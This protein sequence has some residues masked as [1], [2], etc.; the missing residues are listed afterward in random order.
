MKIIDLHNDFLT[1][2]N[3]M[4]I[5]NFLIKSKFSEVDK[6][7]SSIYTT[8]M[9]NKVFEK[10]T[11]YKKLLNQSKIKPKTFLHI[12]DCGF[13][14]NVEDVEKL[15]RIKPFSC[16]LTWNYEN[17]LAGGALSHQNLTK[18]GLVASRQF[19]KNDIIIDLAHLNKK[20]FYDVLKH[21]QGKI[22]CSHAG[23]EAIC[24]H[25]RNIDKNQIKEIIERGG[26]IGLAF[27]GN[28]LNEQGVATFD[29]VYQNINYFLENF[30]ENHLCIGSDF[31][32]TKNT[33]I[34]LNEYEDMGRLFEYLNNKGIPKRILNKIY[35]RNFERFI[36]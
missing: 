19:E 16:G 31:Y 10:I 18:L 1:S 14:S 34:G 25:P 12:E 3:S 22:Y 26:V 9:K 6:L 5:T 4:E 32:G 20:S 24:R 27:V 15:V 30:D 13:I 17:S 21:T 36:K 33:P 11:F 8:E 35:Y 23:F 7:V 29:D 2:L 28:F